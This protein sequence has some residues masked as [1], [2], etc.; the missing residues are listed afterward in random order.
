MFLPLSQVTKK[1][2]LRSSRRSLGSLSFAYLVFC[3]HVNFLN[4]GNFVVVP[5]VLL[6]YLMKRLQLLPYESFSF[7]AIFIVNWP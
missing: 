7:L 3:L 1:T 5:S 6:L 2:L 4:C